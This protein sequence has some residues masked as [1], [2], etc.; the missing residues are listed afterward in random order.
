MRML[1]LRLD[2][3]AAK[4]LDYI[5]LALHENQSQVVKEAIHAYYVTLIDS[6]SPKSSAEIFINSGFIGSFEAEKDLSVNYKEKLTKKLK[7]KH[8]IKEA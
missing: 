2:D 6:E 3:Q 5:K 8:G 1:S 7:E 4:E